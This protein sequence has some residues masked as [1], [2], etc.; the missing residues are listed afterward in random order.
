MVAPVPFGIK[1]LSIEQGLLLI[2]KVCVKGSTSLFY[3]DTLEIFWEGLDFWLGLNETLTEHYMPWREVSDSAMYG[4]R[5]NYSDLPVVEKYQA[6]VNN[7]FLTM[8]TMSP[9][10][11][12]ACRTVLKPVQ[13]VVDISPNTTAPLLLSDY[14]PVP[15]PPAV[16]QWV[17]TALNF[18]AK[19]I[20]DVDAGDEPSLPGGLGQYLRGCSSNA[21]LAASGAPAATDGDSCV[22]TEIDKIFLG[23][24]RLLT[25][26][27]P[28][29]LLVKP[30]KVTVEE[31]L[32]PNY[33][34]VDESSPDFSNYTSKWAWGPVETRFVPRK[35]VCGFMIAFIIIIMAVFFILH[36]LTALPATLAVRDVAPWV[37]LADI[38]D[39][40]DALA[41]LGG[42]G[43]DE[44]IKQEQQRKVIL[45]FDP[46]AT[47]PPSMG[48]AGGVTSVPATA[49]VY[50]VHAAGA[51][52]RR[53]AKGVNAV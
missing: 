8:R 21:V 50:Q 10:M 24:L 15:F 42:L 49:L 3:S 12:T 48:A 31:F 36:G 23:Y 30:H 28:V 34:S 2:E 18:T 37:V 13:A 53:P 5:Y 16:L 7:S 29:P 14:R 47:A 1:D 27:P 52:K 11:G 40:P 4:D 25:E 43:L 6:T 26:V 35:V 19:L 51:G 39:P 32:S 45:S 41:G 22:S 44:F 20:A 33:T 17:M 46:V 9:D 38:A